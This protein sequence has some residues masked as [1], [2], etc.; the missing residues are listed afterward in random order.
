MSRL[1]LSYEP[2]PETAKGQRDA[3]PYRN[4]QIGRYQNDASDALVVGREYRRDPGAH[5]ETDDRNDLLFPAECRQRI[6]R[7]GDPFFRG[8]TEEILRRP[9][10]TRIERRA[11]SVVRGVEM[12]REVSQRLRSVAEPVQEQNAFTRFPVERDSFRARDQR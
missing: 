12:L 11:N 8:R 9:P 6:A 7:T 10:V 5:G 2:V 1:Y 3:Y 4:S